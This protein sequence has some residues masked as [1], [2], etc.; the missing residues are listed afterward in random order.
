M[1]EKNIIFFTENFSFFT[2]LEFSINCMGVFSWS[3]R[4]S[5]ATYLITEKLMT[6]NMSAIYGFN[7]RIK[8]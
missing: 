4:T 1:K 5:D 8:V 2:T 7:N 3:H 6:D